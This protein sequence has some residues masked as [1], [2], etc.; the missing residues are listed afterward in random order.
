MKKYLITLTILMGVTANSNATSTVYEGVIET[1]EVITT[2]VTS[3]GKPLL[4]AAVGVGIGSVFGSGKGNDVAKVAGGLLGG[5][6][7]SAKKSQFY[8]W[9]YIIKAN[10]ALHVVDA[11]CSKANQQCTGS[12]K[13]K[14]VYVING[15]EIVEKS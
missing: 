15:K 3:D 5:K 4:G 9:R 1:S 13:G 8:G 14:A 12:I 7:A 10:D 2:E 11:W 6:M